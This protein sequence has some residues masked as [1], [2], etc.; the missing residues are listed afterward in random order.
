METGRVSEKRPKSNNPAQFLHGQIWRR[1][2]PFNVQRKTLNEKF[3]PAR[4]NF[5]GELLVF[6]LSRRGLWKSFRAVRFR[7]AEQLPAAPGSLVHPVIFYANHNTYWDG[8]LA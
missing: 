4:R 2:L 6:W 1:F 7:A 3:I 8:Y 5:L